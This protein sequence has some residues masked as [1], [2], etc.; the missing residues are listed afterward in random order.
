MQSCSIDR[1]SYPL[2]VAK[3][4]N[5]GLHTGF[6][7]RGSKSRFLKSWGGGGAMQYGNVNIQKQDGMDGGG[8]NHAYRL[9]CRDLGGVSLWYCVLLAAWGGGGG[10]SGGMGVCSPEKTCFSTFTLQGGFRGHFSSLQQTC[11]SITAVTHAC[12]VKGA[13]G[14]KGGERV[15]ASHF[16]PPQ[17]KYHGIPD[18][19]LVFWFS[20]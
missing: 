5:Q 6:G 17:R 15:T 3:Q 20:V 4:H 16:V 14:H 13:T 1:V 8:G 10:G 12:Y 2:S 19:Y 7:A 9:S 18:S 11:E